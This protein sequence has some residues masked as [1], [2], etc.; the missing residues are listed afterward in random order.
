[1]DYSSLDLNERLRGRLSKEWEQMIFGA[2]PIPSPPSPPPLGATIDVYHV[3]VNGQPLTFRTYLDYNYGVRRMVYALRPD[4]R[5]GYRKLARVIMERVLGRNLKNDEQ[6]HHRNG[7]EFDD[8]PENLQV[9]SPRV[10]C[11]LH[12]LL[13]RLLN[14]PRSWVTQYEPTG[15][16]RKR[17]PRCRKVKGSQHFYVH[18][19]TGRPQG[20]YCRRCTSTINGEWR[21]RDRRARSFRP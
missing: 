1:M 21:R 18:R 2:G 9:L 20:S 10:H 13:R 4:G 14:Q 7:C 12:A 11:Q 6:V 17:C 16:W 15:V 8:R 5:F 19:I 3:V